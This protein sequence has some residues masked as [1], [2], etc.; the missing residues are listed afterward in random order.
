MFFDKHDLIKFEVEYALDVSKL[1][2]EDSAEKIWY[3]FSTKL[4]TLRETEK[5]TVNILP[6]LT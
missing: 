5:V 6:S 3:F 4:I 1:R 2:V